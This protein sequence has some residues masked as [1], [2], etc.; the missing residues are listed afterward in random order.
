MNVSDAEK[1]RYILNNLGLKE[2]SEKEADVLIAIACSVRQ[3]AIDRIY[4]KVMKWQKIRKKGGILILTGC[5]LDYDKKRLLKYFDYIIKITEINKIPE[6]LGFKHYEQKFCSNYLKIPA[7]RISKFTAYVPIMTGCTQFCSYCVVPYTRGKEVFINKNQILNEIKTLISLGY[8]E[9]ILLGQNVNSYFDK[10]SN[11]DFADLLLAINQ[12]K[13]KFWVRFISN[14]PWN[15]SDKII[16]AIKS[17]DKITE[18]IH[19]PVQSG[20]D[21][22]L[23]LMNR[24]YT[25]SEYLTLAFKIKNLIKNLCLSTD[26]IVGFPNES[27]KDFNETI[28]LVKKVKFDMIYIARYSKRPGTLAY[29]IFEDNISKEIKIKREKIL[30]EILKKIALENNKN[31]IG[32][33]IDVLIYKKHPKKIGYIGVTRNFKNIMVIPKLNKSIKPGQFLKVK[34]IKASSFN[35]TGEI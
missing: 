34:V 10:V 25:K 5:V 3:S 23:K 28:D 29:K 27:E 20:S 7:D 2:S 17:L 1:I 4:G 11:S 32:K 6:I 15:F 26:V 33:T 19:L 13:G 8:K 16:K 21:K 31:Y 9:I 22:I 35:L 30:T 12:I 14:N 18:Y 24:P